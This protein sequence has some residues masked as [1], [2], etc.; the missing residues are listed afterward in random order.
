MGPSTTKWRIVGIAK[1]PFAGA[2]GYIPVGFIEERHGA[3][4]NSLRLALDRTDSASIGLAREN[5]DRNLEREQVRAVAS[6]SKSDSRYAFDQHMVMIYVFLIIVSCIVGGVGGL[7]LMTTMS[8]NVMERRREM[9]I[10][11][12]IGASPRMVWL[13]VVTEGVVI[14]LLS[15]L[16]ATA[17]AWPLS[18]AIGSLMVS[19]ILR[20]GVDFRFETLGF[21][22]WLAAAVV[23]GAL[24]SFVPAWHA[25]RYE[26][27]E[28]LGYE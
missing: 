4:T 27:R 11:R 17:L 28:A 8:L 22:I 23:L 15:W 16:L 9:G 6:S 10:L 25:S 13:I 21:F 2:T 19:L 5:L 12:A 7:G 14:G 3:V 18:K 24:G 20:G 1:E 26:V